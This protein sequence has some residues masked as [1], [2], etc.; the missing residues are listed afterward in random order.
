MGL[1]DWLRSH[2]GPRKR[3]DEVNTHDLP[4]ARE[5]E[6]DDPWMRRTAE[7]LGFLLVRAMT[8]IAVADR[9]EGLSFSSGQRILTPLRFATA[10][11][12]RSF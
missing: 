8:T 4:D 6:P 2:I 3:G 7:D 12:G 9:S 1:R 5:S 10:S 11:D